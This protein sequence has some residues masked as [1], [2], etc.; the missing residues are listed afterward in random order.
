VLGGTF[1]SYLR[2]SPLYLLLLAP[3][4]VLTAFA[5][6]AVIATRGAGQN[7][8][9]RE[10]LAVAMLGSFLAAVAQQKDLRYHFYP[11]F[12]LA[13]LV[14]GLV[15]GQPAS[16]ASVSVR[17]YTRIAKC[18][19][20]AVA[21]VVLAGAALDALGGSAA[22]RRRRA[23]FGELLEAVQSR[24]RG[25]PIGVLSYHMGSAFPLVNYARVVLA[26][27]FACLWILPATYWDALTTA[28]PIRYHAPAEMRPAERLLNQAVGEDLPGTRPRLLLILR[29][30]PDETPYGF[31]R[32]NYVAYFG[33]DP[34]LSEF[35][36]GYQ[37][38]AAQ[39]QYDLYERVD[40]GMT[41]TGLPP[42]VVVTPLEGARARSPRLPA[43]VDP[44]LTAGA[45]IF[46]ALA[47]GSAVRRLGRSAGRRRRSWRAERPQ[48][49]ANT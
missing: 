23:E 5:A 3:G 12:A 2:S 35:F 10:L 18:A 49:A 20:A 34:R 26:S 16:R 48:P 41:R 33:R 21:L 30:F 19:V 28:G 42:S 29:P 11:S 4:A 38:V 31:R 8:R 6:L 7:S 32:L 1:T 47:I 45:V 15:A 13:T 14:L 40:P 36:S 24:A 37:L 46:I 25:E 39:G 27:R 43:V 17:F 44:E 9:A 22:E